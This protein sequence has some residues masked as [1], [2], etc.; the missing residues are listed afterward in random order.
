MF[1]I[2]SALERFRSLLQ[3]SQSFRDRVSTEFVDSEFPPPFF[4]SGEYIDFNPDYRLDLSKPPKFVWFRLKYIYV[5]FLPGK[6]EI[7][8]DVRKHR[9]VKVQNLPF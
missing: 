9:I 2:I 7:T 5:D 4:E 8:Y 6:K 1:S 3:N